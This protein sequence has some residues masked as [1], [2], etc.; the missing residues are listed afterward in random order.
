[1]DTEPDETIITPAGA[2]QRWD[3]PEGMTFRLD[4][5]PTEGGD[6]DETDQDAE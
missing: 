3:T 6:D 1:V 2:V 5:W 4:V